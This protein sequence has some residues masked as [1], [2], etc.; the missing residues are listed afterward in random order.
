[1]YTNY[2][3][4][5][6][7][8]NRIYCG[9]HHEKKY[10]ELDNYLGSGLNIQRSIKKHGKDA[11]IKT[12]EHV[13]DTAEEAYCAE[14]LIVDKAF[15]K[16]KDTYN[17]NI[18]G[19]EPPHYYGVEHHMHGK[20]LSDEQIKKMIEGRKGKPMHWLGKKHTQASKDKMSATS[21]KFKHSEETKDKM[22]A[23]RKGKKNSNAK[24]IVYNG[25]H[26]DTIY[27]CYTALGISKRVYYTRIHNRSRICH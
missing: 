23:S 2:R 1:M 18:G 24:S 11:F 10:P 22:S 20:T 15:T 13:W 9:V 5:N 19:N 26:Y 8:N 3:I 14:M 27:E 6:T 4:T 12:I 7:V 16:R 17:I 25:V 21:K